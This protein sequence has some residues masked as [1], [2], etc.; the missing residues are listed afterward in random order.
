M[1]CLPQASSSETECA[2]GCL[3]RER[4]WPAIMMKRLVTRY[5]LLLPLLILAVVLLD[6]VERPD[7][8]ET[9]ETIDMRQTQSDY[10]LSDFQTRRFGE[11]GKIEYVVAGDTLAHYPDDDR[12][13]ITAPKIELRRDGVLW[14]VDSNTGRYDPAP[15]L[16]TLQGKVTIERILTDDDQGSITLHTESLRIATQENIVETNDQVQI[17]APTWQLQSTGLRSGIDDGQLSLLSNVIGRY[18]VPDDQ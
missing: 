4:F 18:E 14:L 5:W 6:R 3:C 8:V 10:Y 12:S 17:V 16:F 2:F 7:E 1:P 15:R 9:E 13:E 11:D